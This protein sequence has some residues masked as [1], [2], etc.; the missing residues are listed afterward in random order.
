MAD[1]AV[2]DNVRLKANDHAPVMVVDSLSKIEGNN[3]C[4]CVWFDVNGNF[5]S[6]NVAKTSIEK[7]PT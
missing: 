4:T 2:G 3:T 6:I 1:I 5:Q 7:I